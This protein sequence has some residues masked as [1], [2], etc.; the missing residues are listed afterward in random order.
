M[1]LPGM[2]AD[3][4]L[5]CVLALYDRSLRYKMNLSY[6]TLYVPESIQEP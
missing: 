5:A 1:V 6:S 4:G 3:R 2:S